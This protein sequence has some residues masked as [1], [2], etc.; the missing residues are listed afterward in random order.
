MAEELSNGHSKD[1]SV[2]PMAPSEFVDFR[3]GGQDIRVKVLTLWDLERVKDKLLNLGP[4]GD[5]ITYS[6]DL[7]RII[8]TLT[9]VSPETPEELAE[10]LM[11]ACS[12]GEAR[13]LP[14]AMTDL[15]TKSGFLTPG[16]AEAAAANLGTG[17][18]TLS[19]QNSQPGESAEE[20]PSELS[21]Q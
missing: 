18:S 2:P 8:A 10:R 17:I 11:K 1:M 20:T 14:T 16:E 9:A 6:V 15:L 12:M 21:E 19:P 4:G 3:I 5:W 13:D 7:T